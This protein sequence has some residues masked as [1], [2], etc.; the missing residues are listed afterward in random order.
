MADANEEAMPQEV[1]VRRECPGGAGG[2]YLIVE[3]TVANHAEVNEVVVA[4][5]YELVEILEITAEA[6]VKTVTSRNIEA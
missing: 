3:E 4:G 5:R 6:S 1:F 2:S